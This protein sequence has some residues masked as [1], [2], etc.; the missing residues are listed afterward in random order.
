MAERQWFPKG[1]HLHSHSIS[2]GRFRRTGTWWQILSGQR[3]SSFQQRFLQGGSSLWVGGWQALLTQPG[4]N[5]AG[6][7]SRLLPDSSNFCYGL[8]SGTSA[9]PQAYL[10]RINSSV[11]K[12]PTGSLK[13]AGEKKSCIRVTYLFIYSIC[14]GEHFSHIS[15]V[16]V[17]F[18][19]VF[20]VL[21]G[22]HPWHMEVPR[23]GVRSE[24]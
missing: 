8:I 15:L 11:L 21:L 6:F 24:L 7:P 22:P 18:F 16:F 5:S 23:L 12:K 2:E 19:G 3:N 20:L 4:E 10:P 13:D 1:P 17:V 9:P 14:M